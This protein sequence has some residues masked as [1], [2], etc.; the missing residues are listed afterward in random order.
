M[1][2]MMDP[3]IS[4]PHAALERWQAAKSH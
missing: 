1:G 4:K 2:E 3:A